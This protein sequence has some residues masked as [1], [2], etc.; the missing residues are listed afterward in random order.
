MALELAG[1]RAPVLRRET[2]ARLLPYLRFRHFVRHA[3]AVEFDPEKLRAL[4]VPLPDVQRLLSEDIEGFLAD[5]GRAVTLASG[6][7]GG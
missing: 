6:G 7:G 1:V 4:V 3:Y 5:L 2:S